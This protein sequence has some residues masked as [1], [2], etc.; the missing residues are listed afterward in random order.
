MARFG[1]RKYTLYK[2]VHRME[3]DFGVEVEVKIKS[4]EALYLYR[5]AGWD[6]SSL[7]SVCFPQFRSVQLSLTQCLCSLLKSKDLATS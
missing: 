5:S 2:K 7:P 6:P 3:S 1:D 4:G